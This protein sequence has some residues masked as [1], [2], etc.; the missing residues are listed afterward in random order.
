MWSAADG[1]DGPWF[2][3]SFASFSPGNQIEDA[4]SRMVRQLNLADLE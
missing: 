3:F 4:F 1:L 2:P